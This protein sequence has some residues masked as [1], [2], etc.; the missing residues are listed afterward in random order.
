MIALFLL[1][2]GKIRSEEHFTLIVIPD[3]Q[4]M[5]KTYPDVYRKQ[6]Q[7]IVSNREALN[8]KF[9]MHEG[10]LVHNM[11]ETYQWENASSA[12]S[13]LDGVV[14]YSVVM[15]NHDVVVHPAENYMSFNKYFGVERFL[16]K[17]T[18]GGS[19][20]QGSINNNYHTFNA[21]GADWLVMGVHWRIDTAPRAR[22]RDWVNQ[23]IQ[24][25][26]KHQVI[27][28]AHSYLGDN[29]SRN[30]LGEKMWNQMVKIHHNTTFVFNGHEKIDEAEGDTWATAR[31]TSTAD[32]GNKVHQVLANFQ[33]KTR[34]GW[35]RILH[36]D[37]E[38]M[39]VQVKTYS[40]VNEVYAEDDS[41]Q[42]ELPLEF[43]PSTSI[44][45][46]PLRIA[47]ITPSSSSSTSTPSTPSAPSTSPNTPTANA[48][49]GHP[50]MGFSGD[51][52]NKEK[53]Y[54][55]DLKTAWTAWA[56]GKSLI[57]NLGVPRTIN[58]LKMAFSHGNKEIHTFDVYVDGQ[59]VLKDA[60]NSGS[61]SEF[62][63]FKLASPVSG[64]GVKFTFK[65]NNG[66]GF[67]EIAEMQIWE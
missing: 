7:W 27:F 22:E 45:S 55:G 53:A 49:A 38:N 11:E 52:G 25:H 17:P 32:H 40:V 35:L 30:A 33:N 13:I 42:F 54:D 23:V 2:A 57:Y 61:N 51:Y 46:S 63:D 64:M 10:D 26:P 47:S 20:P 8:I 34:Q 6:T 3:T 67:C 62:E 18:F 58:Y 14:P 39:K 66:D 28:V 48:P 1:D 56:P 60:K 44:T 9:V 16:D 19:Y 31:L 43:V 12:M 15:G 65:N 37:M 29:E 5:S 21:G 24:N 59:L 50:P 4:H 41:N 36:F